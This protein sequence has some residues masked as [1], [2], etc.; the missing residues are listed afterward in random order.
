MATSVLGLGLGKLGKLEL[1]KKF[2]A[3]S[4]QLKAERENATLCSVLTKRNERAYRA[5]YLSKQ[6]D[7]R[8][9]L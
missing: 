9:N 4:A 6:R 8:H 1:G 7:Y 3:Q 5:R 2:S